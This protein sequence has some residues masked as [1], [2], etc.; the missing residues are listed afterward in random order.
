MKTTLEMQDTL[1]RRMKAQA[2]STG[3]SIRQFV[4]E[5]VEDKLANR[6]R[7]R[8]GPSGWKRIFGALPGSAKEIDRAVQ[9]E[10]ERI[11]PADWR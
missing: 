10:F 7:A 5:A 3:V 6:A 9:A 2:A 1:F 8:R 11:D 4:T